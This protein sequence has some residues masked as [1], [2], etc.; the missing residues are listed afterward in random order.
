MS[1]VITIDGPASSGKSTIGILFAEQIGYQF[2]DSGLIYRAGCIQLLKERLVDADEETQAL[3]FKNLDLTFNI[4]EKHQRVFLFGNDVTSLLGTTKVN[5]VAPIIGS[6]MLVRAAVREKQR[7]LGR[8]K[9]TVI[10]G[11]D[12]GSEIFPD[13]FL[14]FYI[15]ASIE[16]RALRRFIQIQEMGEQ[17]SYQDVY[18]NIKNRDLFDSTRELSPFRMPQGAVIIDTTQRTIT[19]TIAEMNSHFTHQIESRNFNYRFHI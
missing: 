7:T 14:K 3:V 13:A 2:I 6:Q 18:E 10:A 1:Q 17:N 4:L 9:D 19:D 15:T 12:V 5:E 8:L 11:R 16:V